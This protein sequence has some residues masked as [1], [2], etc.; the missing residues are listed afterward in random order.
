M[1]IPV[2][3]Q[4]A[5]KCRRHNTLLHREEINAMVMPKTQDSIGSNIQDYS[6]QS[7]SNIHSFP[8]AH[9]ANVGD[10]FPLVASI[11]VRD[12]Y[13]DDVLSGANGLQETLEIQKQ[14]IELLKLRGSHQEK[15][16]SN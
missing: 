5:K 8:S 2:W 14:L 15:W 13:M 7:V 6:E 10:R 16:C 12:F 9:L 3:K 4:P 1:Q 11:F